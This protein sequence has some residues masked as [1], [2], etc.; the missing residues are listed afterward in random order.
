MQH[1]VSVVRIFQPFLDHESSNE[2]LKTYS[3][4]ARSVTSAS[5]KELRRLLALQEARHG[6]AN[7]IP[8]VLHPIMVTSFGSLEEVGRQD[9]SFDKLK[10]EPYQ[11]ILTC[12]RALGTLSSYVFY[13][14]PLF[15]LLT[16][17]CQ[18]M[19][20]PLPPEILTTLDYYQSEE[21][22]KQAVNVVKSR[23]IADIR[24]SASDVD[25]GRMDNII[26]QWSAMTLDDEGTQESET[27]CKSA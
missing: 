24:R 23:Y 18:A 6:W 13:G 14:Q 27:D 11:G 25:N 12:L 5:I 16:Q 2:R 17:T 7:A 9:L 10:N 1:H 22:T 4:H 3:N 15:R 8:L 20:I 21:W 26:S 19:R